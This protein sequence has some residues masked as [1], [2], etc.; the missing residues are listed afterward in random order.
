[1]AE[2]HEL[3][4]GKTCFIISPIGNRLE[5]VGSPGRSRYEESIAM[6][7]EVFEPASQI[8]SL[9]PVR[10]D[11]ISETG[12]IPDQIFT[13][14]RDADVV[15][16]DLSHANPNVMYELGLRHSRLGKITIQVGEYGRLPFDVT[17]IRTIQF[18]RTAAGLIAARNELTDALR[19]SLQGGGSPLRASL[20]FGGETSPAVD[21]GSDVEK[22]LA[23]TD[24]SEEETDEPGTVEMLAEGEEGLQHVSEVL[25]EATEII[26]DEFGRLMQKATTDMRESASQG[27]AGR[28]LIARQLGSDLAAPSARFAELGN[29]FYSDVSKTDV[30]VQY[31]AERYKS[32][33]EDSGAPD[34]QV[35]LKTTLQL[36]DSAEQAAVGITSFRDSSKDL[37]KTS[38]ALAQASR[39]LSGGADRMLEGIGIMSKWRD[40]LGP[41]LLD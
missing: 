7:E 23:P 33:A 8:F 30:I 2:D 27:F 17:T 18:T 40:L 10:A 24:G 15:I 39:E 9:S 5:P 22:S 32:G 36:V 1:M 11:R 21:V 4:A 26:R 6:W 3:G 14:L 38:K 35:F 37:G 29:E 34:A 12:E 16:A 31:A 41:F 13:Y 25:G 20:V 28:L 19:S